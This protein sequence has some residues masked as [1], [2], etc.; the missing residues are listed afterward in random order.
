MPAEHP[1]LL[2]DYPAYAEAARA[3]GFTLSSTMIEDRLFDLADYAE[4]LATVESNHQVGLEV[5]Y[6][7]DRVRVW[8]ID[9]APGDRVPF[10]CH[11]NPYLWVCVDGS[12]GN[13][14]EDD[15][16]LQ[17]FDYQPGEIDFLPIKPGERLIHDLENAGETRLRFIVVELLDE[18]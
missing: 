18:R 5:L 1:V 12:L 10:H 13:H 16:S 3:K 6:E 7:N 9:L 14:R 2:D 8:Q 17:V 4:E 11:T 15:A